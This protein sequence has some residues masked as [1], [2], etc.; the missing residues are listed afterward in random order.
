ME[1]EKIRNHDAQA[2]GGKR[3]KI[4]PQEQLFYAPARIA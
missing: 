3:N 1:S 2:G 4:K